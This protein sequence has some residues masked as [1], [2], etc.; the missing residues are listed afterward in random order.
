ME[1][2]YT[3]ELYIGSVCVGVFEG[4]RAES[5]EKAREYAWEIAETDFWADATEEA[6]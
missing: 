6:K 1:K 2:S 5:E 3:V 4:V